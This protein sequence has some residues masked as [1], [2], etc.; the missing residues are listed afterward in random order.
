M[1]ANAHVQGQCTCASNAPRMCV[2]SPACL[3]ARLAPGYGHSIHLHGP[4]C[5]LQISGITA[6]VFG[7]SGFLGRYLVNALAR[8]GSQVVVPYRADDIDVQHLRQMGDLGQARARL[9]CCGACMQS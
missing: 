7:C 5:T 1:Q 4:W 9:C 8:Q 2:F 6:T 3:A